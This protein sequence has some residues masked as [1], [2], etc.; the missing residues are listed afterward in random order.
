MADKHDHS[1]TMTLEMQEI[2]SHAQALVDATSGEVDDRIKSARG[3]LNERLKSVQT[4][5]GKL[6]R[7]FLGKARAADAVIHE[8]P[9]YAIGGTFLVGL[10]LGWFISRK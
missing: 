8:Q 2:M 3:A 9:Y 10:L 6:E 5:Y 4:E 7:Q 1:Q